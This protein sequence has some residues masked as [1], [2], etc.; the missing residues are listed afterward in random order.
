MRVRVQ[1]SGRGPSRDTTTVLALNEEDGE[2][3]VL[4]S[5]SARKW[6][7]RA[8]DAGVSLPHRN[9]HGY[10]AVDRNES[11]REREVGWCGRGVVLLGNRAAAIGF[12]LADGPVRA[13]VLGIGLMHGTRAIIRAARHAGFRGRHP[14]GTDSCLTRRKCEGQ[15]KGRE[16]PADGQH[17]S[18]ECWSDLAVSTERPSAARILSRSCGAG[19]RYRGPKGWDRLLRCKTGQGLLLTRVR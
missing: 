19:D 11:N 14:A 16:P 10:G 4:R 5:V 12:S 18:L 17:A 1:R 15:K 7:W 8:P 13:G 6:H 9:H 3:N 2:Q